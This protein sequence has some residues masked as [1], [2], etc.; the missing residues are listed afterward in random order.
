MAN[1]LEKFYNTFGGLDTRTNKLKQNPKTFRKGSRNWRYN[2]QDEIQ[3]ANGFQHKDD[4]S[5]VPTQGMIEYKYRDVSTGEAKLDV[6]GVNDAGNL[7]KKR[8]HTL[9][10]TPTVPGGFVPYSFYYN[11]KK[12]KFVFEIAG[13]KVDVSKTMTMSQL[14]T[15]VNAVLISGTIAVYDENGVLVVGSTKLAYLGNCAI[16][17]DVYTDD[18]FHESWYWEQVITPTLAEVPFPTTAS[19]KDHPDY[20]GISYVNQNNC[21]YITDGGFPIKYDGFAAYR[22]GMPR[23][24]GSANGLASS[25]D[26][27]AITGVTTGSGSLTALAQYQ[28]IFQ[29]GFV[30]PNGFEVLGKTYDSLKETLTGAENAISIAVPP[31]KNTDMFPVFGCR[32]DSQFVLD[33]TNQTFNV[34]AGHNVKVGMVLRIPVTNAPIGFPGI[35]FWYALVTATTSTSITVAVPPSNQLRN[36]DNILFTVINDQ[37]INAGYTQDSNENKVTEPVAVGGSYYQPQVLAGAFVRVFR[38]TAN[39]D[40]FSRLFDIEI[41]LDNGL[42]SPNDKYIKVDEIPDSGLSAIYYNPDDGEELPR[43]CKYLADWQETIVQ[44]GRPVDTTLKNLIYPTT[45]S[46][47]VSSWGGIPDQNDFR[48]YYTEV[49]LCDFSS[50]YWADFLNPEG[51]PI[52]GLFE[53]RVDTPAA[54]K[55]KGMIKNKDAFFVFTEEYTAL[56][57]GDLVGQNIN[58]EILE[59]NVGLVSHRTLQDISGAIIG[60]DKHNGFHIFVAGR[61]PVPVGYPISD[62]FQIN[63]GRLDYNKAVSGNLRS[64]TMYF[65]AVG[66]T[67]FVFDYSDF[68]IEQRSCWYLWDRIDA[69]QILSTSKN[70]LLVSDGTRLWQMKT[71]NTKYDFTDDVEAIPFDIRTAWLN[72]DYPTVDKH[73]LYLWINSIQGGF[74]LNV[75]QYNN[76]LEKR[77]SE[78][79][80]IN[81]IAENDCKTAVKESVKASVQ[82]VSAISWGMRN[83]D[84]NA[85]V[86]I[87]GFEVQLSGDYDKAEPKQ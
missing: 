15:A 45:Y 16:S 64:E 7:F 46:L 53:Y 43:A 8:Y 85:F 83:N 81:F 35:S 74:C 1:T 39:T 14:V 22:M 44:S 10:F 51:F 47:A 59:A 71:T 73:Y 6:L 77:V 55:I 23:T 31:I 84:K 78:L 29:L 56:Q 12:D 32:V 42:V 19:F 82:K 57:T 60:M 52:D 27:F 11:E 37:W 9:K 28:Y 75:D 66:T 2:F 25:Y 48:L 62:Y 33:N 79:C 80:D 36:E 86:R 54:D 24:A 50:Y 20:E 87:Q 40:V 70:E 72:E 18:Y 17:V 26:G 49:G 63:E 68:E 13:Q 30:D 67:M 38:T 4:A 5:S 21:V 3:K 41:P 76:Y 65:C 58:S 69:K 61:L 34:D